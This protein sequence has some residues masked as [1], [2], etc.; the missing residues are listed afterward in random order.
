MAVKVMGITAGRKNG[1][2]EILLK[3]ALIACEEAGAEVTMI[4]LKDYRILDCTGCTSCTR[5]MA[6][7]KN[8]G[9]VLDDKDDKKR[10]MDVM[11]DQDAVIVSA[12]TYDLMPA[13]L[14]TTFAQRSLSYETSFLETIGAIAHKDRVAGLIAVGGSTRA[15]QSMA[16]E[17]MQASM[18]TTDFKV[19]DMILAARVPG[20]AQ[21]LLDHELIARAKKMGE[22]IMRSI[23]TFPKE[24][25]W[26]GEEEMGWCPNCHSNALVLGE[27]Q[28]DGTFYPIE[29]QVCGSGGT[30][31]QTE[32]GKWKF[33]I[34]K[35]GRMKD[36]TTV[37]GRA[38]HLDEIGHT[39]GGFYA[40]SQNQKIVAASIGRYKG[41][42]FKSV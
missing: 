28:W 27:K 33:V 9:C 25:Q 17:S 24:R 39:E 41:K 18:F 12:P 32:A 3:E 7:G 4:N 29:C 31:E 36:R 30:L 1:N 20:M 38:R 37:E 6:Q 10:I 22:N 34:Q 14:Y 2:S 8:V 42:V 40:N 23:A 13:G 21:C 19:V 16:L 35:D 26:L 15:W 5:G 11:L